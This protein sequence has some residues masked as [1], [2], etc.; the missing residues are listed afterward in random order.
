MR[1]DY[2]NTSDLEK[3]GISE[4]ILLPQ[5]FNRDD[6]LDVLLNHQTIHSWKVMAY[7]EA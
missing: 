1:D 3:L 2:S 6:F 4:G 5:D 7:S